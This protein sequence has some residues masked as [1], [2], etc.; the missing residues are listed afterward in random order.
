MKTLALVVLIVAA[1]VLLGWQFDVEFLKTPI[2]GLVSMNPVTAL[3][4]IALALAFLLL[5]ARVTTMRRIPVV[6]VLLLMVVGVA[7]ARLL[8]Y[9][10]PALPQ[11]DQFLYKQALVRAS[12]MSGGMAPNTAVNF[13]LQAT[14]MLLLLRSESGARLGQYLVGTS[15]VLTLF[16]LLGYFFAVP[17]FLGLLPYFQWPFTQRSVSSCLDSPCCL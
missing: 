3:L 6:Q 7:A 16:A 13:V 9:M 15:Q 8:G 17:E 5:K 14:A 11:V 12:A 4:F 1:L 10:W 2:R